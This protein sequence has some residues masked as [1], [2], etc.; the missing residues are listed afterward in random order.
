V[1]EKDEHGPSKKLSN[2]ASSVGS[3]GE[4]HTEQV[5]RRELPC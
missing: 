4:A 5:G 2:S 1:W 3:L